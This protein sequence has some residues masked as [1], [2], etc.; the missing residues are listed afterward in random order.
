MSD[1]QF[2]NRT[3]LPVDGGYVTRSGRP[4]VGGSAKAAMW[5]LLAFIAVLL[6]GGLIYFSGHSVVS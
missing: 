3:T 4:Y 2:G 6:I 5:G 1:R